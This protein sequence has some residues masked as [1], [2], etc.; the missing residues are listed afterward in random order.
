MRF[1]LL[2]GLGVDDDEG[3]P[4]DLG[5]PKQRTVLAAL[6]VA[7]GRAVAVDRLQEQVWDD[8]PPANPETSLQAYVSNLR[9]GLE[10]G[11]RPREAPRLLVT[12]PSGYAL[13][14]DRSAVDTARFE[15]GLERGQA[16]L[17]G[18]SQVEARDALQAAL[19]EWAGPPLPELAGR[20]WVD[21]HAAWLDELRRQALLARFEVGLALGEHATLVTRLE[22]A[23]VEQPFEERMRALL[24]LALYRSGRQRE[25]LGA[26]ADARRA[27][28][29]EV[30][31]DPGPELQELEA[32]ILAH[33]PALRLAPAS[34]TAPVA[35]PEPGPAP[36]SGA[37]PV[38]ETA[39]PADARGTGIFVGRQKEL[40]ALVA[41]AGAAEAAGRPV[42]I[43]GEPGIGKT[44]L[45]EELLAQLPSSTVVAWGRCSEQA[46]SAG[47][48]PVI[49]IGRQLEGAGVLPADLAAELLPESDI[50]AVPGDDAVADRFGL[51]VA[52][53]DVLAAAT[54]PTVIVVDDLHWADAASLRVIEFL[55][56]ELRRT[57]ALVVITTRAVPADA[58]APLIECL[59][60][61][62]RQ[63][64]ALRLDLDGLSDGDVRAWV[65]ERT[66]RSTSPEVASAIHD[67]TGGN[68]F[69][70]GELVE[71]LAGEGRTVDADA[72]R[73]GTAVPGAVQDVVRRRVSRLPTTTQTLLSAASVVGRSFDLD[74][75]AAVVG[76]PPHDLLDQLEA[77][78]DAG[79][80]D[81]TDVPG[82]FQF[83]HAL[84]A[85][86]LADEV[87][88]TRR[89]RIHAATAEALERLRAADL[90]GHLSELA[91]HAVEGAIAGTSEAAYRW[92]VEAARQATQLLAHEQAAEHWA[93]ATRALELA[94]PDDG[95]ARL[96]AMRQEGLAWLRVDDVDQGYAA[97]VRALD[98]ALAL[99]DL[100]RV[101]TVAAEMHI[102]GVWNTGEVALGGSDPVSSLE[103]AL[104][105][106]P[107]T[108]TRERV[109]ATGA[110][111]EA[112]YW[113]RPP[114]VLDE[115]T[116][117]AVA[118]ARE[119]GDLAT[120]GRTLHK[121]DQ[122]L[123]RA[124]T[125][126]PRALAAEE[127]FAMA[128]AGGLSPSL[129]AIARF[130]MAGV[131]WDRAEV[132]FALEQ[133]RLAQALAHRIGSPAL[134]T[135]TD[136]F[137]ATILGFQGHLGQAEVLCDQAYELYRRTRRWSAES[138][139]AGLR[140][141]IYLEQDRAA[142]IE[143]RRDDLLDSPY[144]PWFQEGYA[145][146]LVELGRSDEAAKVLADAPLP[147]LIDSWLFLGLVGAATH[148]RV[149]LG[150]TE[151][152]RTL[153][154]VLAP[155]A[156]R[157]CT[158]GTG[159]AFG[160]VHLALAAGHRLLGDREVA[161][162]H[163][164]ASVEL[165]DRAGAGPDLARAL[166]L[167]A[168]LDPA[169]AGADRARAAALVEARDL[170]LLRRRL[171]ALS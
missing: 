91:H 93:R 164:D 8:A 92:S 156:G 7:Q 6:L 90:E 115:W 102:D 108:P 76:L 86:T 74:V 81:A 171:A 51:H 40:A 50:Q 26:L 5:G 61:L 33:D 152:V 83:S 45:V 34:T 94:R 157:L 98:L 138:L 2:G 89:A 96:E 30:G 167:R 133:A 25:A 161:L 71:L 162:L 110:L 29:D 60:E 163:A 159:A 79:L 149:A 10:P 112:A 166:L 126:E 124:A 18:G 146:G 67:R 17:D 132:P 131:S 41:A 151:A 134:M 85:D 109:L 28:R 43:C 80:V 122:A 75:L 135:Q 144:R 121:R 117:R 140:L 123:W 104:A 12:R 44:R 119:L 62:A 48:W 19:D 160:D 129:E 165:L 155:Y 38:P 49:Q 36:L 13:L 9:R 142:D 137:V 158:T 103:R 116:A 170:H 150:E 113:V 35:P 42:V 139:D 154:D 15:D 63:P 101:A 69:F 46:T 23:V 31:V 3:R 66:A 70:V 111:A 169:V 153:V 73:R 145:Y 130:G 168:E 78:L 148:T 141:S 128:E 87:N 54:R 72:L 118:D 59:G 127:L 147:P 52:V 143:A 106:L 125:F 14:A 82:R 58:P 105:A 27:L 57:R 99:G 64:G 97:L 22:Q 11:R 47:Y 55:A 20:D 84:V 1:R 24:A 39:E 100:E 4:I 136:W 88:P 32:Q 107:D 77:A 16:L 21:E 68:P 37:E 114:E 120:L 56:G 95:E 65:T 53:V